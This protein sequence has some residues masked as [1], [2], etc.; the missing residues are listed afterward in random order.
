MKLYLLDDDLG[1]LNI[2]KKIVKDRGLG[3]ICGMSMSA[4]DAFED[5]EH[6]LPDLVVVDLLMPGMDGVEF[7]RQAK[8]K[9]PQMRFVMLSQVSSKN[10]IAAAYE[11]GVDFYI[12]KPVN[13]V[14]VI[15]VL[16]KLSKM[17]VVD[18][19]LAQMQSLF[20]NAQAPTGAASGHA[21]PPQPSVPALPGHLVRLEAILSELGVSGEQGAGEIREVVSCLIQHDEVL[22]QVSLKDVCARFSDMPKSMEQRL[23]RT[24]T[25]GM[26]H[27]AHIGVEDY[28]HPVFSAYA[29]TLFPFDQVRK[30]MEFI[31]GKSNEHGRVSLKRFFN[32]LVSE[33]TRA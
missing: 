6:G 4:E 10:M 2:L 11:S 16:E 12:Q 8:V 30:E 25:I 22:G 7:V 5:F 32:A 17:M 28:T 9:Y 15:S 14:E 13:A 24:A 3:E 19:A 21:A 27:L 18:N 33:C 31:R 20:F 29:S 26:V 1:V 23:R